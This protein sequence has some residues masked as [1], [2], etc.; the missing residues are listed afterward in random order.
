MLGG[1]LQSKGAD[2]L[3]EAAARVRAVR[4]DVVILIAGV[5]PAGGSPSPLKRWLRALLERTGF[6]PSVERRVRA[7]IERQGLAET[8]RFIGLRRDIP[9][10]L[11]ASR[12][13]VWP[14]SVSHFARPII[15]AGAMGLPVVASDFPSSREVVI[16]GTTGLL[17]PPG[18]AEAFA[19]AILRLL[20]SPDE[21]RTMGE[22]GHALARERYDA[23]RN[24]AGT[25]EVYESVLADAA[26]GRPG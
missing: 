6:L 1:A 9:D 25:M 14:A 2:V 16:P 5:P 10:M 23:A 19:A 13:L 11:A 26:R 18:D 4:P 8:V 20:D 15:E 12:M 7:L 21:A 17:V 3:V 24:A 22:A